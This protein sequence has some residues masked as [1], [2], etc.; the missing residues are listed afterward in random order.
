MKRF[1]TPIKIKIFLI[2]AVVL[3][4]SVNIPVFKIDTY[5]NY[6]TYKSDFK[7]NKDFFLLKYEYTTGYGWTIEDSSVKNSEFDEAV[8]CNIFDPRYLKDNKDFSLDYT[9]YLLVE[10]QNYKEI[11]PGALHIVADSVTVLYN[12]DKSYYTV[13]DMSFTGFLKGISGVFIPPLRHS[14]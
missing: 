5:D 7:K 6:H 11:E 9:A 1:F 10:S 12:T 2:I 4:I 8:L 13:C 14:Y 3:I